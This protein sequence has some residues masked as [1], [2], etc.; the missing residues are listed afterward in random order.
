MV[1]RESLKAKSVNFDQIQQ[2][3]RHET[4][5][6]LACFLGLCNY[7]RTLVLSFAHVSDSLYKASKMKVIDWT[8]DLSTKFEKLKTLMLS[9][10]VV[11]LP[12]VEKEFILNTDGS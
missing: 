5:T 4:G 7:Y 1:S 3:P 10:P 6:G 12:D 2:W 9:A 11:R 8:A